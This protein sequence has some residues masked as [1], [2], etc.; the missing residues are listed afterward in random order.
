MS[1]TQLRI[2][3]AFIM[4]IVL[5]VALALGELGLVTLFFVSGVLLVDEFYVNI[6]SKVRS[7]T[8]YFFSMISFIVGFAALFFL[9]TTYIPYS[10]VLNLSLI[11]NFALLSYLFFV[12]MKSE[13]VN[14]LLNKFSFLIGM[15]FLI[16][17]CAL[18]FIT[19]EENWLKLVGLLCL[20][21]FSVDSGAWF[22]GRK[23]GNKKLWPSISPKKTING[24]LG[25]SMLGVLCS[26][27]YVYLVFDK[28][29]IEIIAGLI[30]ISIAGQIGDLIESKFKRQFNI[31]DSSNLI[32]GHGGIYDR[33]DSL[34][35]V[36]PFFILFVKHLL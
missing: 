9:E 20:L 17:I 30:F 10:I 23:F 11:L 13:L 1:N 27:L 28:I 6:L 12:D 5:V 19:L 34:L 4:I 29:N 2:I 24:S 22:F 15:L 32:P 8:N 33:L 18:V 16:P 25:G 26:S 21:N 3:S 35:F 31:K 36:G 14:R 7:S